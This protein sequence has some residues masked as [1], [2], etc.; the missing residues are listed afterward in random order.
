MTEVIRNGRV[1]TAMKPF[2]EIL[3]E[4]SIKDVARY[5]YDTFTLCGLTP[6]AYHTAENGWPNHRERYEPAYPFVLAEIA[7]DR[8]DRLLS[9]RERQGRSLYRG[10]CVIC[11][12]RD[13]M[14]DLN[15]N[16]GEDDQL[17]E[18]APSVQI[19]TNH[20]ILDEPAAAS[21]ED[22]QDQHLGDGQ[23][24]EY[25]YG[26]GDG[27]HDQLVTIPDLTPL[28]DEGEHLYIENCA[29]CH[30][31]DGTGLN[32]VGSFLQPNPPNFTKPAVTAAYTDDTIRQ[33]ILDGLPQTSMPA[34][35]SVMTDNEVAAIIAY[36]S[37][38]FLNH[39]PTVR[40]GEHCQGESC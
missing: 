28:E 18:A 13:R 3:S 39:R 32:W 35:G 33:V 21:V 36:L 25:G 14:R 10:A 37:R 27:A 23:N 5:A 40:S 17:H 31:A 19:A 2:R 9:E 16:A 7:P 1:G 30:A 20:S 15:K 34:F 4:Q 22:R 11:H 12:E 24:E 29:Y 6:A 26:L 38:A 8:P